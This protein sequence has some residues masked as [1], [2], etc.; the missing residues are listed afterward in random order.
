MHVLQLVELLV[1]FI[2]LLHNGLLFLVPLWHNECYFDCSSCDTDSSS[3]EII[4]ICEP[5]LPEHITIDDNNNICIEVKMNINM[6]TKMILDEDFMSI[7]IGEK[8]LSI[9][10][11]NLYMKREQYYIIQNEGLSKIKTDIYD[12]SEKSDIIVHIILW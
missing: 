7:N 8:T 12:V 11:A 6:V 10:I 4:V 9:P 3:G 1:V 2:H 5:G